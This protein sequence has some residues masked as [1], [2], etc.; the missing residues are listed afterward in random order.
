MA[1]PPEKRARTDLMVDAFKV[2][3]PGEEGSLPHIAAKRFTSNSPKAELC[4]T[5]SYAEA[6]RAVMA[7][8]A[9]YA[10]VPIENSASGSIAQTYDLIA[11]HDVV[12]GGELGM[13]ERYCICGKEGTELADIQRVLSHTNLLDACSDFIES[14][15]QGSVETTATR[16]STDAAR[17]VAG[18]EPASSVAICTRESAMRNG[19]KVLVSNIGNHTYMEARYV[20]VHRNVGTAAEMPAPF[21]RDVVGP[22]QKQIVMCVVSDEPGAFFKLLGQWA[23]RNINVERVETRPLK[24]GRK[25]PPGLPPGNLWDLL[26]F[27]EVVEPVGQTEEA[28]RKLWSSLAEFSRWQRNVG[29]FPSRTSRTMHKLPQ[30]WDDRIDIMTKA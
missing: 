14:K 22:V 9:L 8:T 2:M 28:R 27:V 26:I 5:E 3:Y 10:C 17:R 16:S 15:L 19:L 23:L 6:F 7:G 11:Q 20:L 4:G 12:I 18:G 21:P 24:V 25:A 30:S 29:T 1:M 13:Q